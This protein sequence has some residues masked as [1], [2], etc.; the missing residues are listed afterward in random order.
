MFSGVLE[1]VSIG[2]VT[3][4]VKWYSGLY[5]GSRDTYDDI[6]KWRSN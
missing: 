2:L 5:T 6:Y 3:D 4:G 1:S